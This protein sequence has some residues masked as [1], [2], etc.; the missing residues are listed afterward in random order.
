MARD[1]VS[2]VSFAVRRRDLRPLASD[3]RGRSAR[4]NTAGLRSITVSWAPRALIGLLLAISTTLSL[5]VS[6]AS[7]SEQASSSDLVAVVNVRDHLNRGLAGS[8]GDAQVGGPYSVGGH[9][10]THVRGGQAVVG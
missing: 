6:A 5:A 1:R 8:L 10:R 9:V 4:R 2:C 7:A 3:S